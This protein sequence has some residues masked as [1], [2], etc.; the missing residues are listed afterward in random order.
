MDGKGCYR[1]NIFGE[2]LRRSEKV[3]CVYLKTFKDGPTLCKPLLVSEQ[4][5][6]LEVNMNPVQKAILR[7]HVTVLREKLTGRRARP[8]VKCSRWSMSVWTALAIQQASA[9][10]NSWS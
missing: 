8:A 1:D 3:E 4:L 5:P 6:T 7:G 2:R 10:S 9:A